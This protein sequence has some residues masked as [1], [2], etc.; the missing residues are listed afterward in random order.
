[1]LMRLLLLLLR[2]RRDELRPHNDRRRRLI[3]N[4]NRVACDQACKL[5]RCILTAASPVWCLE[6]NQLSLACQKN[7]PTS[8]KK[9]SMNST[10]ATGNTVQAQA[11]SGCHATVKS[12]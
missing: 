1:M 6:D 7:Y 11:A 4:G 8:A 9:I 3:P 12:M 10:I 2:R 5:S